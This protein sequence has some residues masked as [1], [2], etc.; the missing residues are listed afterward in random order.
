MPTQAD[1]ASYRVANSVWD[2]QLTN[3]RLATAEGDEL[4]LPRARLLGM[5]A[6]EGQVRRRRRGLDGDDGFLLDD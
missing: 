6:A 2:L 3:I 1:L 5:Q 4:R